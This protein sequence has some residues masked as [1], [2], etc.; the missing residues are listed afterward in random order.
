MFAI[1]MHN[2]SNMVKNSSQISDVFLA[3]SHTFFV[4]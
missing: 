2:L 4:P 3:T 1:K